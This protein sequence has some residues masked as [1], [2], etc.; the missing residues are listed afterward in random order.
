MADL[1]PECF[2]CLFSFENNLVEPLSHSDESDL[3]VHKS[4][5]F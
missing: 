3:L 2:H 1:S 5:F 4:V